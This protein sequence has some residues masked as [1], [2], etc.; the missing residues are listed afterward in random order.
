MNKLI[1]IVILLAM[2]GLSLNAVAAGTK[3]QV[4]HDGKTIFV[5][6]SALSAHLAHGDTLGACGDASFNPGTPVA[7]VMM[8]CAESAGNEMEVVTFSASFDYASIQPVEP[9]DC[10]VALATLLDAGFHLRSVTSGG[11]TVDYLLLGRLPE[12]G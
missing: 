12:D 7:V 5:S 2:V 9:V 8:R 11:G 10:A 6:A 1:S 3:Q 4:C